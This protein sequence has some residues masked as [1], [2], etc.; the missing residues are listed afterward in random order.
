MVGRENEE[1][2]GMNA[3]LNVFESPAQNLKVWRLPV[4]SN[5]KVV[6]QKIKDFSQRR[7]ADCVFSDGLL[8]FKGEPERVKGELQKEQFLVGTPLEEVLISP[9]KDGKLV[10]GLLYSSFEGALHNSGWRA[11]IGRKKRA[12]PHT[13]EHPECHLKLRTDIVVPFGLKYMFEVGSGKSFRLWLDVYAPIWSVPEKRRLH[14]KEIDAELRELYFERALLRPKNRRETTLRLIKS[15]F[16]ESLLELEFC[17]GDRLSF[18]K[19]MYKAPS[20]AEEARGEA[21]FS[22]SIIEEPSLR[23]KIGS[24]KNPRDITRLQAYGY[25]AS[26]KDLPVKAVLDE[27]TREDFLNF[28]RKMS[29]GFHGKYMRWPGFRRVTGAELLFN[30]G[31]DIIYLDDLSEEAVWS[32]LLQLSSET[33]NRTVVLLVV[34]ELLRKLYYKIKALALQKRMPLQVILKETLKKDPLEFTVMNISVALYANGG[35]IPWI[36][37]NPLMQTRGLFVGISFH[38]DHEAKNIYYG[39]VEVFDKF[40]RHLECKIRMYSSPTEI[41]SVRGL[42]IPGNEVRSILMGLLKEYDPREIIFHKSAPFHNEEKEAIENVCRERGISYCLVHIERANPYRV[43]TDEE[44][45]TPIRGT[46]V[47]DATNENRALL[48][49][50]GR[51]ML[52]FGKMKEWFGIGTPKPL[53]ITLEKNTTRYNLREIA[54]QILAMT[55]L[56]WNT[57]EISVRSPI[58]LKYSNKAASLASHLKKEIS[59]GPLE[60]AEYRFLI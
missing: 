57:T 46:I 25:G 12:L 33:D 36:L 13:V 3:L 20:I 5:Q 48:N 6:F 54:E 53:E 43:Y 35:G 9:Q 60:I 15:I 8:Y 47:L 7:I 31:S 4:A 2:L 37:E 52:D 28:F 27:S 1:V 22:F 56:D 11:P 29:G 10:K 34:P 21:S 44:S 51:S 32:C 18:S 41:R 38:L 16:R 50:T 17:D 23:F 45:S 49:T 14:V 55:K 24:S 30:E 42:F 59:K 19:E 39:V 40:G 26:I 58:T